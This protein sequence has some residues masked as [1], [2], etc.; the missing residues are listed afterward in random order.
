MDIAIT[1]LD[2]EQS[3]FSM[4][5]IRQSHCKI[6]V[7]KHE[8]IFFTLFHLVLFILCL[9]QSKDWFDV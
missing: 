2:G 3:K 8:A 9:D 6:N 4:D 1:N 7:N 5:E